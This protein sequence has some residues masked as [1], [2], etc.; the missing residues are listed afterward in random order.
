MIPYLCDIFPANIE[1]W[2]YY[3]VIYSIFTIQLVRR[4]PIQKIRAPPLL[5]VPGN[6]WVLISWER[7]DLVCFWK[8]GGICIACSC[9]VT[10]ATRF[11]S[12]NRAYHSVRRVGDVRR[13]YWW[14]KVRKSSLRLMPQGTAYL[15]CQTCFP[16]HSRYSR[17]IL[18]HQYGNP[19]GRRRKRY[20]NIWISY[21]LCYILFRWYHAKMN[22]S[23]CTSAF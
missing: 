13:S 22:T 5:R 14:L 18:S 20:S 1:E 11:P 7:C 21:Y 19:S 17:Y 6:Q 9:I 4:Y 10:H 12:H 3:I 8:I 16:S 2:I 15:P 23:L